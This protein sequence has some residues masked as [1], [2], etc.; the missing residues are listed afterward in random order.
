[1]DFYNLIDC[2]KDEKNNKIYNEDLEYISSNLISAKIDKLKD[3]ANSSDD[4]EKIEF[5]IKQLKKLL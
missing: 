5:A 1:M 4:Y 2:L 3:Y